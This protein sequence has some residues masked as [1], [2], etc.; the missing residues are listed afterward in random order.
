ML[1]FFAQ[2]DDNSTMINADEFFGALHNYFTR[3]MSSTDKVLALI[4]LVV[5]IAL[6]IFITV[7]A[8]MVI[9][10]DDDQDKKKLL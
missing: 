1:K 3:P 10:K 2:Q 6:I 7:K 8:I 4:L 5:V 9:W